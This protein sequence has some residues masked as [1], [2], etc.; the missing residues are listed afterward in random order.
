MIVK[1]ISKGRIFRCKWCDWERPAWYT[2]RNGTRC[3]G[4]DLLVR[5][6]EDEHP[7]EVE[8]LRRALGH[9]ECLED[10]Q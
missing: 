6:C 2:L 8:E 5:H 4:G 7:E 1:Y 3:N 9:E 10:L